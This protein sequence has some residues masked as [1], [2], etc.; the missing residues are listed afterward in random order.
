[1]IHRAYIEATAFGTKLIMKQFEDNHIPVHTV[2]A[3]GG[4]HKE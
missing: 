4:I 3:S 2:Y 1:M